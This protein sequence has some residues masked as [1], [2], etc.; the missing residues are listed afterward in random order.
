MQ[1]LNRFENL[2]SLDTAD[3]IFISAIVYAISNIF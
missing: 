3:L 2:S 1:Q